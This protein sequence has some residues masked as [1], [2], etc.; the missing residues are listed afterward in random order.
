[1]VASEVVLRTLADALYR[2]GTVS[3]WIS[4]IEQSNGPR[5]FSSEGVILE[6]VSSL[7]CSLFELMILS[8]PVIVLFTK[9]DALLPVALGKLVPADRQLPAQERLS[10]A[11]SLIEGIFNKADV[12]GRLSQMTYPPKS[13]VQIEG[14]YYVLSHIPGCTNNKC[15]SHAQVSWGMQ[16]FTGKNCNCPGWRSIANAIGVSPRNKHCTVYQICH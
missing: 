8:V 2:T 11:K 5:K 10:K 4:S 13:C 6:I 7:H 16:Q 1:M 14:L 15:I 9:F 3:Q 12:W